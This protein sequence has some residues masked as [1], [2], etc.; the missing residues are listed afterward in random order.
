MAKI[1]APLEVTLN[2]HKHTYFRRWD[3]FGAPVM[4]HNKKDAKP[5]TQDEMKTVIA[6][7]ILM[8][9]KENIKLPV[10]ET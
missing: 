3:M 8:H 1:K 5:I 2:G 9:G 4:T 10:T 7:L 6:K